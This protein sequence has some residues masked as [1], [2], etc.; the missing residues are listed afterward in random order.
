MSDPTV[1]L[2]I[3]QG[4]LDA[5]DRI[6][7]DRGVDRVAVMEEALAAFVAVQDGQVRHIERAV[8]AADAGGP[9]L[10]DEA[11]AAWVRDRTRLPVAP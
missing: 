5:I 7:A 10:D 9:F 2:P 11:M 4:T 3:P 8:A 1:T 6:A